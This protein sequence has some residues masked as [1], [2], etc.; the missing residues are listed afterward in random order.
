MGQAF[1]PALGRWVLF[2]TILASSMAFIDSTALNVALPALQADLGASGPDLLWIVNAYTLLLAALLLVGGA[3]GDRFGRRR[4]FMAGIAL[5][6]GASLLCGLAPGTG[7]LIAARALQGVG[8]ALMVPGSLAL[9]A[10]LF[11]ADQRGRAVG[12]WSSFSTIT[13]MVGPALGGLLAHAGLWRAVFLINLPLAALTLWALWRHIPESRDEQ[14]ARQIDAPGAAL[15]TLGLCGLTYGCIEAA[16]RSFGAP[17]VLAALLGGLVA[18]AAFGAVEARSAH[19]M[20]PLRL[21][22]SR[23]FSGANAMTLFLYAGLSGSLFFL[24]LNLIQA[25]GYDPAL[26]G[27]TLLP[28]SLMLALLSRWAG[29]LADR[30]GPRL[31]LTVGPALAAVGFGLY[32]LPG[33]TGGPRD[34]WTTFLP[35]TLVLGLGMACTVAPLS[36]TVIGSAPSENAGVASGISNAVSRVAGVLAVALMGG[37]GVLVFRGALER[38]TAT[39]GLPEAAH[40]ALL[41]S[42]ANLGETRPPA[43]LSA[44]AAEAVRLAVRLAFVDMFR[45]I[46]LA[47]AGLA[48]AAALLSALLIRSK[49]PA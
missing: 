24:P 45:L 6:A 23:S 41:A 9:L 18:L 22:R 7:A 42:A 34:Y 38:H 12:T 5:F 47:A 29:A 1:S 4:V 39:L 35:A 2:A 46:M 25:Q 33:L 43:G 3:L 48:A 37:A 13:T 11:P 28:F 17:D 30:L 19:P 32:A 44:E 49:N 14:A 20:V 31:P 27:L 8:G 15:A 21:F 36:A 26:V 16:R 10:A 40:A